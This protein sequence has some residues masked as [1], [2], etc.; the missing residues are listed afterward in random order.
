MDRWTDGQMDRW[1]DG[2]AERQAEC[3]NRQKQTTLQLLGF[4][5]E[6]VKKFLSIS[7]K[8]WNCF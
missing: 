4:I 8:S 6:R 2:Q 3:R 1:I 5:D 7:A